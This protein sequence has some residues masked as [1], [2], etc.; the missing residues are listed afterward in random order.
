MGLTFGE[1]IIKNTQTEMLR[2]SCCSWTDNL[3]LDR[4]SDFESDFLANGTGRWVCECA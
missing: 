1:E 4:T 3:D 2:L